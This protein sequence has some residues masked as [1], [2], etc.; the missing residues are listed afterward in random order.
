MAQNTI[1][2]SQKIKAGLALQGLTLKDWA[3]G[4]GYP[5]TTVW[6]AVHEKRSGSTSQKILKKLE[7]DYAQA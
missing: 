4:N 7:K 5:M 6:Q 2:I 1:K 3:M